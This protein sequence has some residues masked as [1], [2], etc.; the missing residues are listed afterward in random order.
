MKHECMNWKKG[1]PKLKIIPKPKGKYKGLLVRSC[2]GEA[3][4]DIQ[5]KT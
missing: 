1:M 2:C 5:I 3:I 4:T